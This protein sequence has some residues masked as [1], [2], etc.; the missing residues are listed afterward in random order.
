MKEAELNQLRQIFKQLSC[1]FSVAMLYY[2]G[3]AL[4]KQEAIKHQIDAI[5]DFLECHNDE[6]EILLEIQLRMFNIDI[7]NG[8]PISTDFEHGGFDLYLKAV[9]NDKGIDLK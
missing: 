4:S 7:I 8:Q 6:T 1:A 2:K 9:L 5:S 3:E